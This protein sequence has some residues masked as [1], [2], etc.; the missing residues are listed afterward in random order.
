MTVYRALDFLSQMG[1]AHR[2]ESLNAYVPCVEK[3][4][5]HKD[6]QYLICDKCG[7]VEELHNHEID[8]FI[9]KNL[10][11]SG[12]QL[13]YKAMELHGRCARCAA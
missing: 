13:S 5:D 7:R 12:F 10:A 4:C 8:N 9:S 6:S 1:L 11:Q 3:H 2:I